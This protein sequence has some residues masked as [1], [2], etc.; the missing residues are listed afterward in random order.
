MFRLLLCP[1][2]YI[3]II[4]GSRMLYKVEHPT[5][6]DRNGADP[7]EARGKHP[8]L[9]QARGRLTAFAE[10]EIELVSC[11]FSLGLHSAS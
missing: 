11:F 4:G 1:S 6:A 9:I 5:P 7:G 10:I 8:A 3:E 2:S